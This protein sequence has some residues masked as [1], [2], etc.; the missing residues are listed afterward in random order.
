MQGTAALSSTGNSTTAFSSEQPVE[1]IGKAIGDLKERVANLW[2]QTSKQEEEEALRIYYVD[3]IDC[4]RVEEYENQVLRDKVLLNSALS[5]LFKEFTALKQNSDEKGLKCLED[6]V[7]KRLRGCDSRFLCLLNSD[8]HL[9][10]LS[11]DWI[12]RALELQSKH[13]KRMRPIAIALVVVTIATT[14]FLLA[15]IPED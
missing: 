2:T 4:S 5:G 9:N 7:I 1:I 11:K 3:E 13:K 14:I 10:P 8:N 12:S 15:H 6:K